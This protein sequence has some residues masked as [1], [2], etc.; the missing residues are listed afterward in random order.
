MVQ[1]LSIEIHQIISNMKNI[2]FI[3]LIIA[4]PSV[5]NCQINLSKT[6][7]AITTPNGKATGASQT[8]PPANNQQ[9]KP[10]ERL[11]E[12]LSND[13]IINGL[14]ET[15]T[16]SAQKAVSKG[17]LTDGFF[18]NTA[19]KIP[20]PS[21]AKV[22]ENKVR[23]FGMGSQVDRFVLTLNRAAE[24]ASKSATPI[25][26]NAVKTMNITDGLNILRGGNTAATD[27]LRGKTTTPLQQA[28]QPIVK[29][30]INKVELTKFW[31]PI[32]SRYNQIPGV[33][34]Q[35]P[36]L[37]VYVTQKALDGLFFL[38]A[39]EEEGIRKDPVGTANNVIKNLFGIISN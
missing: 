11:G 29:Q 12:G 6:K 2:L 15:L 27:Y 24:E 19:I 1:H 14:K 35:N 33:K 28:F 32:V 16:V 3:A 7:K 23:Q 31:T 26:I 18:K 20:F 10:K 37:E 36:N 38:L 17:A 22:V 39:R 9:P 8:Q 21:E 13:A 25:L 30:A 4:L 5:S 34:R